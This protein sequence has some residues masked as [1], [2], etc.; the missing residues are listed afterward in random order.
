MG[1]LGIMVATTTE[2]LSVVYKLLACHFQRLPGYHVQRCIYKF[3]CI[4]DLIIATRN[5][6]REP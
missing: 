3:S 2:T 5:R 4:A 1:R 6:K